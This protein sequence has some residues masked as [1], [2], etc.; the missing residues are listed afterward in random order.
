MD[1]QT[2]ITKQ[3]RDNLLHTGLAPIKPHSAHSFCEKQQSKV[4]LKSPHVTQ[5]DNEIKLKSK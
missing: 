5:M 1:N 4:K 2:N 3:Q